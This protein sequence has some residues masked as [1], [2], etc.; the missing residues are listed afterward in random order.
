MPKHSALEKI[1]PFLPAAWLF[2]AMGS[3]FTLIFLLLGTLQPQLTGNLKYSIFSARPHIL[4]LSTNNIEGADSKAAR[5]NEVFEKYNC[6]ITGYGEA[7]VREAEKNNIP[8]WLVASIAFQE[9]SCGKNVPTLNGQTSNNFY[10]WGVWGNNVRTFETVEEGI[11]VV[12][13]YMSETFYSKGVTDLCEIMKTYTPP[14]N[15]SWCRGVQHFGDE[16]TGYESVSSS[17][18][19]FIKLPF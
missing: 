6:P 8:Y 1:K 14:S 17:P 7:F 10:G 4:G 11:A 19:L 3:A 5:L 16:I 13:K 15:G 12:S 2:S 9:S 18:A